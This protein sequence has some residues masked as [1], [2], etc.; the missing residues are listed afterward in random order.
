MQI[1]DLRAVAGVLLALS[2][3][4]V[5]ARAVREHFSAATVHAVSVRLTPTVLSAAPPPDAA[6]ALG[7]GL[8]ASPS[9]SVINV[10]MA[11][12]PA[13]SSH[14]PSPSHAEAMSET[15]AKA[16][17]ASGLVAGSDAPSPAGPSVEHA[18]ERN[19]VASTKPRT[20]HS[21]TDAPATPLSSSMR[22]SALPKQ[23]AATAVKSAGSPLPKTS[24][25]VDI[26]SSV[27]D[28][29]ISI[30]AGDEL[31]LSTLLKTAHLGDTM[32][33]ECPVTP[34]EHSFRVV[35]SRLDETVMVEK[36]ST[37]QIRADASNF[38]GIHVNRRTKLLLKHETSLEVVWPSTAAP[39]AASLSPHP[40]GEL[41]L[42]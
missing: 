41:A 27:A 13:T 38:L 1:S 32:R 24:L 40:V 7:T 6:V 17:S 26:V 21:T 5:G 10:G 22:A 25:Q 35:L 4:G 11:E 20:I 8:G 36:D 30:F 31:L 42:R 12:K 15:S 37:S 2:V 16:D 28:E 39:V 14:N 18:F 34:G 19:A 3:L 23:A 29:N 9:A 33:F